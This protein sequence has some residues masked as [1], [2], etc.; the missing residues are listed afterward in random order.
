MTRLL[1]I[2]FAIILLAQCLDAQNAKSS[3]VPF[4]RGEKY[5]FFDRQGNVVIKPQFEVALP[6]FEGFALVQVDGLWGYI[7]TT[8]RIVI[9]P[10][11]NEADNFSGGYARIKLTKSFGT[12]KWGFINKRGEMV[13]EPSYIGAGNFFEGLAWV[14]SLRKFLWIITVGTR[15]DFIDSTGP[16][17]FRKDLH[18]S[19]PEECGRT[20]IA[21]VR[22]RFRRSLMTRQRFRKDLRAYEKE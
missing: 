2:L 11:F 13:V 16:P 15:F 17:V 1:L 14:R 4:V 10:Q 19:T 22:S 5:G 6:F 7:D 3:L 12:L 9:E 18:L 21:P 20:L 8:G